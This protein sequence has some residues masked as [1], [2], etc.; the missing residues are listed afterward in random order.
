MLNVTIM[1]IA[2]A[3][4]DEAY[5]WWDEH[6]SA[7]QAQRWYREIYPAIQGL[8]ESAPRR[9]QSPEA[10]ELGVDIREFYFGLG[11]QPTHRV[12]FII[13]NTVVKVLRVLHLSRS[14]LQLSD[15]NPKFA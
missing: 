8:S 4:I 14:R 10:A 13:E 1:P 15:I 12:V 11:S 2:E 3:D 5:K 6:R 9:P 7:E